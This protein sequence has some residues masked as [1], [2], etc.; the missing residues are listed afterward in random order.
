MGALGGVW[1]RS[2]PGCDLM[3]PT[4]DEVI[5]LFHEFGHAL[6][7]LLSDVR[8]PSQSGT[9]VPTDVV[10]FPSQVNEMWAWEPAILQCYARHHETGEPM[11]PGWIDTLNGARPF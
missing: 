2:R 11:P 1:Q 9:D 4:W 5:T 3:R 6:H 10:E 7:A 8:Y